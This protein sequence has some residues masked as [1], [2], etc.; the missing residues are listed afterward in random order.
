MLLLELEP[1]RP[2]VAFV[3]PR[4]LHWWEYEMLNRA[5]RLSGPRRVLGRALIRVGRALAAE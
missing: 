1:D 4:D 3:P 2:Y 5:S